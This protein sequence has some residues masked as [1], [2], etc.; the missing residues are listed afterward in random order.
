MKKRFNNLAI[1]RLIATICVLQFHLFFILYDRDIPYELLLSKGVQG[2]TCLSGFLYSQKVITDNKKFFFG[3]AKKIVI[4]ALICFAIMAIWNLVYMFIFRN[5]NYISLFTDHRVYNDG[6]LIQPGN[7]YYIAY[8]LGCY[9]VTPVLQRND[10]WSVLA[11]VL[12]T[13]FELTLAFFFGTAM[14]A[15]TYI[16]GYYAGKKVFKQLTDNEEKFSFGKFFLYLGIFLASLA[17]YI[18][19]I[20]FPFGEQYFL[21]HLNLMLRTAVMTIFG[22]MSFF[23]ISHA[24]RWLNKYEGFRFL[25]FTDKLSLIIYLL[26]QAFMCGA[27]NVAIWVEPMWAKTI[28]VYAFTI[29]FSVGT[30]YLYVL[31][32]G[33]KKKPKQVNA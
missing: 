19:L 1:Y 15:V 2:L 4:P 31:L 24:F 17:T 20:E 11:S 3:N 21:S 9:L 29:V 22:I 30:Y 8:I 13:V 12:V 14:I 27:M 18:L 33:I 28:L 6:L 10:R 25:M 23:V 5:W 32:Q 16:F 26:N 7:Y